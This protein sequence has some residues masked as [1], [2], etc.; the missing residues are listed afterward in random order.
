[1]IEIDGLTKR[2]GSVCALDQVSFA[3]PDGQIMEQYVNV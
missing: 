3:V 2:Y 1:M